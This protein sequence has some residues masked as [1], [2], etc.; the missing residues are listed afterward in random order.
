[1]D[2]HDFQADKYQIASTFETV[3]MGSRDDC[4]VSTKFD[5]YKSLPS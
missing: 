2:A 3:M 5:Q 1:M 4:N